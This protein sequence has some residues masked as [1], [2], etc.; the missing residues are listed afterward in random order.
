MNGNDDVPST[1]VRRRPGPFG[2]ALTLA[3]GAATACSSLPTPE[4]EPFDPNLLPRAEDHPDAPAVV[5]VDRGAVDFPMD[6][7]G[8]RVARLSR[9]LRIRKLR[10]IPGPTDR[11]VLPVD[12]G[13][14]L[15]GLAARV[16]RPDAEE[17]FVLAG[18]AFAETRLADGRAGR[19]LRLPDLSPGDVVEVI[20]DQYFEDPRLV[21]PWRFQHGVPTRRS[22]FVVT[23]PPGMSV[24]FRHSD[25]GRFRVRP[26]DRYETP[27]GTRFSWTQTDLPA[28]WPERGAP[29]DAHRS[30]TTWLLVQEG[31]PGFRTWDDVFVWLEQRAAW[32][33]EVPQPWQVRA[34][35][36][37]EDREPTETAVAL[38]AVVAREFDVTEDAPLW[39][40]DVRDAAS[41]PSG[42]SGRS[43]LNL[44]LV[45]LMRAAGLKARPA[46][47][48]RR[49]RLELPPDAPV[50]Y[51]VDGVL[52]AVQP[53]P[54]GDWMLFDAA[55]RSIVAGVP[56]AFVQGSRVILEGE[57]ARG[58][59]VPPSAPEASRTELRYALNID[60][61]GRVRGRLEGVSTGVEAGALRR[62][63]DSTAPERWTDA[64][65]RALAERG[66]PVRVDVLEIDNRARLDEPLRFRGRVAARTL[67]DTEGPETFFAAA[68]LVGGGLEPPRTTRR[69]PQM[70]PAPRVLDVRVRLGT[71][72]AYEPGLLPPSSEIR[73]PSGKVSFHFETDSFGRIVL[74]RIHRSESIEIAPEVWPRHR[75]FVDEVRAMDDATVSLVRTVPVAGPP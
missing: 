43:R 18:S 53:D 29:T 57:V 70:L 8:A 64:F 26:P 44:F 69:T 66:A 23:V 50:L 30:P 71:S 4:F 16:T 10:P 7:T 74:H 63:L 13:S 72:D 55:A 39:R 11:V 67:F 58:L 27:E 49:D 38:T 14:G 41:V 1:A 21:P 9:R 40:A 35:A 2:A 17:S 54:A 48:A 68:Q 75:R 65:A 37:A 24:D 46:L 22:E 59:R 31:Q 61:K 32:R 6:E 47:F 45:G 20:Y 34:R 73:G 42:P 62:L 52:A 3:L 36:L 33:E 28:L 12:P 60:R 51:G 19:E 5:V 56:P 15:Y 25:D